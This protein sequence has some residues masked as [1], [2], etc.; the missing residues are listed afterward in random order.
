MT[1]E[2]DWLPPILTLSGT[3]EEIV[4]SLYAIFEKGFKQAK[5]KFQHYV[6]W[7]DQRVLSGQCYEEGFWH[8]I[9]RDDKSIGERL[10]DFRRAERLPW[11]APAIMNSDDSA[12]KV[13]DYREGSGQLRTYLWLEAGD[14]CIILEKL[15]RRTQLAAML[16][17]AFHVDSP[18][19]KRS[20]RN[21]LA[22]KEA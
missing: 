2:I 13:W 17:T 1:L 16:V 22:K 21:K 20:L 7:W 8:L 3:W 5:P 11:C 19:Q 14:Y 15:K 9:S 12:V 18:S 6:V 4:S 10:P